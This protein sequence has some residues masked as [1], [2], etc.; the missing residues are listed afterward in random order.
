MIKKNYI[1]PAFTI[2][3]LNHNA[4]L[5]DASHVTAP[6]FNWSEDEDFE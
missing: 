4:S 2:V 1:R 3:K 6:R 5:L